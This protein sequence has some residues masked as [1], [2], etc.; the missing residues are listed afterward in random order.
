MNAMTDA[1]PIFSELFPEHVGLMW[2]IAIFVLSLMLRRN[3][4]LLVAR[5]TIALGTPRLVPLD[6][7]EAASAS[8]LLGSIAAEAMAEPERWG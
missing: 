4:E 1:D 3:P 8:R 7:G 2:F 5:A 6:P